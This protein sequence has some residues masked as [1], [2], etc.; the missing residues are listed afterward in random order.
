M[1]HSERLQLHLALEESKVVIREAISEGKW[2]VINETDTG[3]IIKEGHNTK[4]LLTHVITGGTSYAVTIS[5][6][7]ERNDGGTNVTLN[8]KMFG[9]INYGP[10]K[11]TMGAFINHIKVAEDKKKSSIFTSITSGSSLAEQLEKLANLRA[12]GQLSEEEFKM[13]KNRLLM[14]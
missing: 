12:Q 13:A 8:G 9:I 1:E 11:R 10:I 6:D 2:D 4:Q 5:I 7:L 3:F 14:K